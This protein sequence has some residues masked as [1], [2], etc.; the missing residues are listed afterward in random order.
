MVR[1]RRRL[2]FAA[3]SVLLLGGAVLVVM[4]VVERPVRTVLV[5]CQK[6][7]DVPTCQEAFEAYGQCFE[8][9]Y[10]H[11]GA[12]QCRAALRADDDCRE[13]Y[14]QP[15]ESAC[16]VV[17]LELLRCTEAGLT[18]YTCGRLTDDYLEC[19]DEPGNTLGQCRNTKADHFECLMR[20]A[21]RQ[22]WMTDPAAPKWFRGADSSE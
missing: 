7:S 9:K 16:R 21:C 2:L 20:D 19:L 6:D 8:E 11:W 10:V 22:S 14:G 3:M 15:D 5:A 13:R 18:P 12:E 1:K 17:A 4:N